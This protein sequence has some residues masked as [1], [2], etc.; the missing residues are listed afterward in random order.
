MEQKQ[1]K[2]LPRV[3]RWDPQKQVFERSESLLAALGFA[4]WKTLPR[5]VSLVGAGGKTSTMYD[6]ARELTDAGASVLVTTSTHIMKPEHENC[7]VTDRLEHLK[8]SEFDAQRQHGGWM[9]VAGKQAAGKGTEQK[10]TMPEDLGDEKV[11]KQLLSWFDVVLIEA[12]GSKR[13][14]LKVPSETEPVLIS[15]TGLVIACAGLSAG[16]K[17]FEEACFRFASQGSWLKRSDKDKI[18]PEDMALILMDERGSHKGVAGCCYRIVLNQADS[19]VEQKQAE[20]IARLLPLTMQDGC[21]RTSRR[22][23]CE[24]AK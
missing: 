19:I 7:V 18:Q 20:E 5:V 15:Q 1:I 4:D 22:V 9:L 14:P 23:S 13:L 24:K 12:D 8:L 11:M 21:V 10:L 16:T 6:L 2:N 3:E 17:T